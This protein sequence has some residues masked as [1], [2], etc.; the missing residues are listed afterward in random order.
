MT[1]NAQPG[2]EKLLLNQPFEPGTLYGLRAAVQAHA[3]AAGMTEARAGD[4]MMAVHELAA[5][6]IQHGAGHGR[7]VLSRQ[8]TALRCVVEDGGRPDPHRAAQPGQDAATG[9]PYAPGH[10]LW[11]ARLLAD[12]MRIT[13][14]PGGTRATAVFT[15]PAAPEPGRDIGGLAVSAVADE[16][17]QR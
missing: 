14:G 5:N 13:S 12:R 2:S 4:V 17:G 15:L 9:W 1:G 3:I 8:G 10:G 16:S 6:A 11:L 7:V